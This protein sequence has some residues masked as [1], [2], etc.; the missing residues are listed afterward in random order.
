MSLI[1]DFLNLM[2]LLSGRRI[3]DIL[4]ATHSKYVQ[5][6]ADQA[7]ELQNDVSASKNQQTKKGK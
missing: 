1:A 4:Y 6:R 3:T 5:G 7:D 2:T